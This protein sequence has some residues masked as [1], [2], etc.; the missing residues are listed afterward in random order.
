MHK[1]FTPNVMNA[2]TSSVTILVSALSAE[3]DVL[4]SRASA[5]QDDPPPGTSELLVRQL[6]PRQ[7]V[8]WDAEG[9]VPVTGVSDTAQAALS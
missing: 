6:R 8:T 3:A 5:V 7:P 2:A 1:S 9:P 4:P